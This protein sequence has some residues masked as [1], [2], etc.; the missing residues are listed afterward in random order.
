MPT[1][2]SSCGKVIFR[3]FGVY[4]W[5]IHLLRH[6]CFC[7]SPRNL[8]ARRRTRGTSG[9]MTKIMKPFTLSP[10]PSRYFGPIGSSLLN[11]ILKLTDNCIQ[12]SCYE[13]KKL[14]SCAHSSI[15]KSRL[16]VHKS[17]AFY[18]HC[19]LS[20]D[21]FDYSSFFPQADAHKHFLVCAPSII[22]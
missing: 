16:C 5:R 21:S 14:L 20:F 4:H 9:C 8:I 6:G 19:S 11:L 10:A 1:Q 3:H 18:S 13:G 2:A 17:H 22:L 7:G 15:P 12:I